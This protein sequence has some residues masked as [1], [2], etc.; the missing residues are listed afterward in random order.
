MVSTRAAKRAVADALHPLNHS[1]ILE[2]VL[3]FVGAGNY[4]FLALVSIKFCCCCLNT[5][6][7]TIDG[8]DKDNEELEIRIFS[9]NTTTEAVYESP[10]RLKL[11]VEC[12]FQVKTNSVGQF[13]AGWLAS[14]DTLD[15]LHKEYSMPFTA[16][17]SRGAAESG[18]I[19]KL[20]WLLD[21]QH[22]E[23]AENICDYAVL[24]RTTDALK[25]LKQR[26]AAFTASTCSAA[27]R[28]INA[29]SVVQYLVSEGCPI[30][31]EC[32]V[33]AASYGDIEL[34]EFLHKQVSLKQFE[35]NI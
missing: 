34:L 28:S 16:Q 26:G 24:C 33:N 27:A 10:S 19:S 21:E 32:A 25:W 29:C 22:C 12:G 8:Y 3:Q 9:L 20:T 14:I 2:Q 4:L 23:Q 6:D 30:D 17:T 15:T 18:C 7:S 11:A 35:Y 31:A 1:G 5:E 13:R